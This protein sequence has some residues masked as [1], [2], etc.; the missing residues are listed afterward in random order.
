MAFFNWVKRAFF[1][2]AKQASRYA[3]IHFSGSRPESPG[4]GPGPRAQAQAPHDNTSARNAGTPQGLRVSERT[5]RIHEPMASRMPGRETG[6][7]RLLDQLVA[8]CP[9]DV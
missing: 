9:M 5:R 1:G 3:P 2:W 8:V 4:P 6:A 7:K